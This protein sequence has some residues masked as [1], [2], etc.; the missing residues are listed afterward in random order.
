MTWLR[1][2]ASA[3]LAP[4]TGY[5]AATGENIVVIQSHSIQLGLET[6]YCYILLQQRFAL[7]YFVII[8]GHVVNGES[9]D[10]FKIYFAL[11]ANLT[12]LIVR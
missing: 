7:H 9:G 12:C 6:N 5:V 3:P 2:K 10:S 11:Q 4:S 8:S 1:V